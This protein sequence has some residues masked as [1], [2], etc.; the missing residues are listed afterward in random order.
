MLFAN[1]HIIITLFIFPTC[2]S[3]KMTFFKFR[4]Y[5]EHS[6]RPLNKGGGTHYLGTHKL[7][8]TVDCMTTRRNGDDNVKS[9]STEASSKLGEEDFGGQKNLVKKT[10]RGDDVEGEGGKNPIIVLVLECNRFSV[11]VRHSHLRFNSRPNQ[12]S[13]SSP[14]TNHDTIVTFKWWLRLEMLR[15]GRYDMAWD[16]GMGW[17][18]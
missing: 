1:E 14:T 13:T 2:T 4:V 12:L 18:T 16:G 7:C 6:E 3:I 10:M 17:D 5:A 11:F 8:P 9:P 15:I